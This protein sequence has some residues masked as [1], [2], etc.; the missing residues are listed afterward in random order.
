[1]DHLRYSEQAKKD[2]VQIRRYLTKES[3]SKEVARRFLAKLRQQ[4][5]Q[6]ATLPGMMGRA[7]P[8]LFEGLRSLPYGNY[9]ILF[10]YNNDFV[11]IVSIIEGHRDIEELFRP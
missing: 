9:V 11:E 6:V 7:R 3:G 8:E 4:C 1:M 5:Q 10:R 2:L